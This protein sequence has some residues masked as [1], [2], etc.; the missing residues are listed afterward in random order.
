MQITIVAAS[1]I[2]PLT[3]TAA[4]ELIIGHQSVWIGGERPQGG[5]SIIP[6]TGISGLY[7][8]L[9]TVL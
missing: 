5:L 3:F 9:N 8:Y 2:S 6:S 4:M 1:T 7:E